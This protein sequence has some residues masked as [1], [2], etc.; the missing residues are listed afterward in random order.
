MESIDM[1][2]L[3]KREGINMVDRGNHYS[4][5][6]PLH[7]DNDPSLVV[8]KNAPARFRCFG[9]GNKG[10]A[11]AFIRKLYNL[12]FQGALKYLKIGFQYERKLIKREDMFEALGKEEA[13]GVD[14]YK[15]YG[16]GMREVVGLLTIRK[17]IK[18]VNGERERRRKREEKEKEEGHTH[19]EQTLLTTMEP[20]RMEKVH[21]QCE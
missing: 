21:R 8:Y 5:K 11:I 12:S 7:L 19:T 4:G 2:P 20:P 15:K 17:I 13:N 16:E 14:I 3:L 6:C 1:L 9:C 10:D 18:E